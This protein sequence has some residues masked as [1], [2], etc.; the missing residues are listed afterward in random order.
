MTWEGGRGGGGQ[1]GDGRD[2]QYFC[3]GGKTLY[4]G[5]WYFIGGPNNLLETMLYYFTLVSL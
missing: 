3:E 4:G 1:M 5:T 2:I